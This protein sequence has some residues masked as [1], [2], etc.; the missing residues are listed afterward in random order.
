M[1]DF[2]HAIRQGTKLPSYSIDNSVAAQQHTVA[3][4][5][6]ECE[7]VQQEVI[8]NERKHAH[9]TFSWINTASFLKRASV[10]GAEIKAMCVYVVHIRSA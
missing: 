2:L 3:V 9:E 10:L 7:N 5:M 4:N 6:W 8:K 1:N